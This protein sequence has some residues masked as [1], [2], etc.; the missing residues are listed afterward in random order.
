SLGLVCGL[1]HLHDATKSVPQMLEDFKQHPPVA[2]PIADGKLVEYSAPVV[3]EP[4]LTL[5]PE[6]VGDGVLIAGETAGLCM[7]CEFAIPRM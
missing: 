3:P 5:R 2:P 1:H 4:R 6:W 7:K